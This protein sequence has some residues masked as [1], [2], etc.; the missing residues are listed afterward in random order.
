MTAF[1]FNPLIAARKLVK[2]TVFK[3]TP[4]LPLL[5]S[6]ATVVLLL[7]PEAAFATASVTAATGGSA[8]SA[9]TTG[10]TFT[11]LTGPVI[12]EGATGDVGLG[13]IILN[14][15]SGVT[16]ATTTNSVTA[17]VATAGG[18]CSGTRPLQ[19]NGGAQNRNSN[20]LH[21]HRHCFQE[22]HHELPR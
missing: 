16:F 13:A 20:R 11:A 22:I 2:K 12:T 3:N 19:L 8:I 21:H 17:T 15:P 4:V 10:G 14:A 1:F 5:F 18:T 6:V 9:D 7:A